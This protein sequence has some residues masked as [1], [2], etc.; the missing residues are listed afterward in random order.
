VAAGVGLVLAGL[1][2]R[3][4]GVIL[5]GAGLVVAVCYADLARDRQRDLVDRVWCEGYDA[6]MSD[7]DSQA[8]LRLE[9]EA[10][11]EWPWPRPDAYAYEG[12]GGVLIRSTEEFARVYGANG[13]NDARWRALCQMHGFYPIKK[14]WE[15]T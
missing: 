15:P 6:A 12:D 5:L 9:L 11:D 13:A 10:E 14:T 7:R 8:A 3:D 4:A 1:A 2:L